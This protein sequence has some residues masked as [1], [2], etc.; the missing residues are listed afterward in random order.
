MGVGG[1]TVRPGGWA[2][3]SAMEL[4]A[5]AQIYIVLLEMVSQLSVLH[6]YTEQQPVVRIK[7]VCA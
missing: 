3:S 7:G 5:I 2:L 1:V 4:V 6:S